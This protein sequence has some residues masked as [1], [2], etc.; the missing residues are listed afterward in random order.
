M[1]QLE[2]AM[3]KGRNV[4]RA[5]IIL[6]ICIGTY[7]P[8][9]SQSVLNN[10]YYYCDGVIDNGTCILYTFEK[11]GIFKKDVKGEL[12]KTH[13][14][15]GYYQIKNDS[16]ILNYN[17]TELKT[18]S[19]HKYKTYIND[20]DSINLSIKVFDLSEKPRSN[21]EVYSSKDRYGALTAKNGLAQL[22]FKKQAGSKK[23]E[24]SNICCGN[25]S[26]IIDT[27]LNYEIEVYLTEGSNKPKAIKH[28]IVKYQILKL[29]KNQLKLKKGE[30]TVL[31]K[32]R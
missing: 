10:T 6:S 12:G 26:I 8:V 14:G 24:V 21:I 7:I 29:N 25:H 3:Q 17:L 4:A 28:E 5:L 1:K 18:N 32:K 11:N 27:K 13:Y 20:S 31:F 16:L 9:L 23:I 19:F 2:I 22:N 30:Q 15:K